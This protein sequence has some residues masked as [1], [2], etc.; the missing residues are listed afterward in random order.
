MDHS[1]PSSSFHGVL[2]ARILE[3]VTMPSSRGSSLPGVE[4]ASLMSPALA[5]GFLTTNT[6]WEVIYI[7]HLPYPFTSHLLINNKW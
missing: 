5:R 7:S 1:L 6:T 3:W 4:P 2:Q